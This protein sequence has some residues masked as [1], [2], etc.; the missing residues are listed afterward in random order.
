MICGVPTGWRTLRRDA[1]HDEELL[2]VL[3]SGYVISPLSVG[4]YATP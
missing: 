3:R 4:R 2:D 1:V